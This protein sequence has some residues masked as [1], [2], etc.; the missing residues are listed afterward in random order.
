[1]KYLKV[2]WQRVEKRGLDNVLF[3]KA[4]ASEVVRHLVPDE[5]VSVFHI[6]FPDPWH[7]KRH[8]KRRLLTPDFFLLLHQR[9]LPGGLLE[10]ATDNFDY[11]I[12]FK[13]ALIEAGEVLWARTH[14]TR[15]ARILDP[16]YKTN[17]EIKY[18][19]EGRDLYYLELEK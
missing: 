11:L 5:S 10:I 2:G 12:A 1:W 17:F 19:T 3:F 18:E 8:H 16:E 4:E 7:K 13:A 6:Y 14:E 9:L 15:N